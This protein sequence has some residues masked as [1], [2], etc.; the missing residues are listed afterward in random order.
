MLVQFSNSIEQ[1]V[2]VSLSSTSSL[3]KIIGSTQEVISSRRESSGFHCFAFCLVF[4]IAW[5]CKCVDYDK[6]LI[7]RLEVALLLIVYIAYGYSEGGASSFVLLTISSWFLVISWL[8]APYIFNPSGFEWQKYVWLENLI[9]F[10]LYFSQ[11]VL[12]LYKWILWFYYLIRTVE[13]FDDWTSW[14]FYKG[15]V[16]VK[17]EN[18]WESWWDEEQVKELS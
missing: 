13:D 16:G 1:L 12:V 11:N 2:E 9:L 18:S 8:F 14:L 3:L 10:E 15:G 6:S 17:G 4:V 7:L 5:D